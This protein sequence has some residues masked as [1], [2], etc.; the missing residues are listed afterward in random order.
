MPS[1]PRCARWRAVFAS[2]RRYERRAAAGPARPRPARAAA[3]GPLG[4]VDRDARPARES[5]RRASATGGG[6]ARDRRARRDVLARIRAALG[7]EPAVAGRSRATYRQAGR[8]G[9]VGGAG[10]ALLRARRRLPRDRAT[11][12]RRR[13]C[14]TT[15]VAACASAEPPGRGVPAAPAMASG[16]D[17]GRHA[18]I[19]SCGA[20]SLDARRRGAHRLRARRSPRPGRSCSTAARSAGG[21][22]SRWCPTTTSASCAPS[23]SSPRCPTRSPRSGPPP[24]ERRPI[25][26]VS[27]PSA[28]SDIELERVEGVHGPRLLDVVVVG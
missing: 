20:A 8:G 23:R 6:R 28:T 13:S 25:T 22:R 17:R 5:R 19:P 15:I 4:G 9:R 27:G 21:A 3:G 18:T 1:G 14:S 10:R 12:R 16:R 2:R 7:P 11:R 26:L 24:R